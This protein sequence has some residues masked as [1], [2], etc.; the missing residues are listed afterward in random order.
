MIV[1]YGSEHDPVLSRKIDHLLNTSPGETTTDGFEYAVTEPEVVGAPSGVIGRIIISGDEIECGLIVASDIPEATRRNIAAITVASIV[2]PSRYSIAQAGDQIA[3]DLP[4]DE[5]AD[6][7]KHIGLNMEAHRKGIAYADSK[8][9][10]AVTPPFVR[11]TLK[12]TLGWLNLRRPYT[13]RGEEGITELQQR[14]LF[15]PELQSGQHL[16]ASLQTKAGVRKVGLVFA[17]ERSEKH[18]CPCCSGQIL[19][20]TTRIT[21]STTKER[22]GFDHHHYHTTCF[23]DKVL[24]KIEPDSARIEENPHLA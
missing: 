2:Y 7:I 6:V 10:Y 4:P 22:N 5:R 16:T 11:Q 8:K 17:P 9:H 12:S 15:V 24:T 14:D 1:A 19:K 18:T 23:A 21:M 3:E 20:G 13:A